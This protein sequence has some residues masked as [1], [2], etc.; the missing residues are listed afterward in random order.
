MAAHPDAFA[1]LIVYAGLWLI[2]ARET[3]D[4]HAAATLIVWFMTLLI[5]RAEHRDTQAL[6]AK[7]DELL[8]VQRGADNASPARCGKKGA[9]RA[10]SRLLAVL[11]SS[12]GECMEEI[13]R[14]RLTLREGLA[15]DQL[16]AFVQQQE[17]F[18]VELANGSDFE[19][20]LRCSLNSA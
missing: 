3:F 14:R 4:W 13:E 12:L 9:I 17:A 16:D 20:G 10:E 19:R 8:H 7:L 1:I 15:S 2:L 6:K 11:R 5:H 18:G